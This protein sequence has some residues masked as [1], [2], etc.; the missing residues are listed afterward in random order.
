MADNTAVKQGNQMGRPVGARN[1]ATVAAE[2]LVDGDAEAPTRKVLEL[3]HKGDY[4]ACVSIVSSRYVNFKLPPLHSAEDAAMA[5]SAVTAAVAAG[6]ITPGDRHGRGHR[7][8][9]AG[10]YQ[11]AGGCRPGN[12]QRRPSG[13]RGG[14]SRVRKGSAPKARF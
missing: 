9:E 8:G 1:R 10:R 12:R 13:Q 7:S 4:C 6:E 14:R 5:M 2:A 11:G 3:T